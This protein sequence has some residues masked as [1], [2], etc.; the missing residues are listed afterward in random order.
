MIKHYFLRKGVLYFSFIERVDVSE[1]LLDGIVVLP[2]EKSIDGISY[3]VISISNLDKPFD[4]RKLSYRLGDGQVLNA[5]LLGELPQIYFEDDSEYDESGFTWG[6]NRH[7]DPETNFF[8]CDQIIKHSSV[9]THVKFS[10]AVMQAYRSL[11]LMRDDLIEISASNIAA[12]IGKKSDLKKSSSVRVDRHHLFFSVNY[13]LQLIYIYQGK[14]KELVAVW[15]GLKAYLKEIYNESILRVSIINVLNPFIL[16]AL[17]LYLSDEYKGKNTVV[18][19]ALSYFKKAVSY[20][21]LPFDPVHFKELNV[22]QSSMSYLLPLKALRSKGDSVSVSI[23]NHLGVTDLDDYLKKTF[24]KS[25]RTKGAVNE[26]LFSNFMKFSFDSSNDFIGIFISLFEAQSGSTNN[27]S[28]LPQDIFE[29][30]QKT[31]NAADILRELAFKYEKTGDYEMALSI[32]KEAQELR[33]NG[34]VINKKVAQYSEKV[35]VG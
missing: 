13:V 23:K 14:E 22:P 30:K 25:L 16:M 35:K 7:S 27:S 11:E 26:L 15:E 18:E 29:K 31:N 12:L 2:E 5:D 10:L 21:D 8:I 33:P 28:F 3:Y 34:P 1:F 17:Y 24:L 4:F 9:S 20:F 19:M 6:N 32:M